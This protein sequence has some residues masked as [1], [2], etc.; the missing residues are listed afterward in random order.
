MGT[1]ADIRLSTGDKIAL[2]SNLSTMLS[3]GIT[4]LEAVDSILTDAKGNMRKV[5]EALREDLMQGK[6][7]H[8]SFSAFPKVFDKVTINLIKASEQAG[9]LETTLKDLKDNILREVE[10]IDRIKFAMIYPVL[11]MVVFAGVLLVILTVVV[12]KI[13]A[14]FKRLR[15]DLPLPTRM[16]I[17]LSDLVLQHTVLLLS[18]LGVCLLIGWW[19][20]MY[21]R[22]LLINAV[23]AAPGVSGLVKEID[24]TR[25]SRALYLL[26]S[27]GITITA[28]ME[29]AEEVVIKKRMILLVRKARE[30]IGSGKRLSE[31][32]ANSKGYIPSI[33]VK[34]IE[35]GERSGSL[36][37]SMLDVGTYL[38][39]KV[40]NTL[41]TLTAALEPL[42]LVVVGI[43]VGGMMLAIISPIYGLIGQI[44]AR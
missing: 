15:I 37:R 5:L 17:G 35:V 43:S 20:W 44:G 34:L 27:S 18:G 28:A 19:F 31:G 40:S 6:Q 3:A 29:L 4:I 25:F 41:K 11:V 14:V 7:V 21:K 26:L 13:G 36:D 33:M 1:K 16:L 30:M 12:P 22:E 39:Y 23:A 42:M 2:I 38:D 10:F 9:T 8:V 24:L 32:L